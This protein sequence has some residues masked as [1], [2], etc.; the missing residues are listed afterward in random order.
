MKINGLDFK[1][2]L[3]DK[4]TIHH[5]QRITETTGS[6]RTDSIP[7]RVEPVAN[8]RI[9]MRARKRA[10]SIRSRR[11]NFDFMEIFYKDAFEYRTVF[12]RWLKLEWAAVW[13]RQKMA[14]LIRYYVAGTTGV[15]SKRVGFRCSVVTHY[16]RGRS[17][18]SFRISLRSPA[19]AEYSANYRFL[20][21]NLFEIR[22]HVN[23][24][25]TLRSYTALAFHCA[26]IS[27]CCC[28][29][30]ICDSWI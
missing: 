4:S 27:L 21:I 14:Y 25:K 13:D 5:Q 30:G 24:F 11:N 18:T 1:F 7:F 8:Q 15:P 29:F 3:N 22:A 9:Y 6:Q 23:E 26:S 10:D 16:Q 20:E 17:C 28:G 2:K 12:A 19:F